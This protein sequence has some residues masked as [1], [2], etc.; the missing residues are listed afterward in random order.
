MPEIKIHEDPIL[1]ASELIAVMSYPDDEQ[2]REELKNK[3]KFNL[4]LNERDRLLSLGKNDSDYGQYI[5]DICLMLCAELAPMLLDSCSYTDSLKK[6]W[7]KPAFLVGQT[8][9]EMYKFNKVDKSFI[10]RNRASQYVSDFLLTDTKVSKKSIDAGWSKYKSV[11]H[12]WAAYTHYVVDNDLMGIRNN[13]HGVFGTNLFLHKHKEIL[14]L[15]CFFQ[16]FL[17]SYKSSNNRKIEFDSEKLWTVPKDSGREVLDLNV[18][19]T[20]EYKSHITEWNKN[21]YSIKYK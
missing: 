5:D 6:S 2:E 19:L 1:Q 18:N 20:D 8:V 9:M 16:E 14:G 3:V 13:V 15:S 21:E 12:L 17:L 11:A 4:Y 10:G 7:P